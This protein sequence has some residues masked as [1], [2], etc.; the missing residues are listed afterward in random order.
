VHFLNIEKSKT[1]HKLHDH[2]KST[3]TKA[4]GKKSISAPRGNLKTFLQGCNLLHAKFLL[5]SFKTEGGF[6]VIDE[7][8]K[9]RAGQIRHQFG[10]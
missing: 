10:K 7:G 8:Q 9:P 6:E 5:C 2:H 3:K 1:L 4:W